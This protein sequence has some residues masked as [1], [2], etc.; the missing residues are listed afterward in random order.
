MNNEINK[1]EDV[2]FDDIQGRA[3]K[4]IH[5]FETHGEQAEELY[6]S[7]KGVFDLSV[8][9]AK[10]SITATGGLRDLAESAKSL[11]GIRGDA[12]A[13][14]NNAFS[15]LM[16]V[17]DF[18]LKKEKIGNEGD[19]LQSNALLMRQLAES[20]QKQNSVDKKPKNLTSNPSTNV[21]EDSML[22][23]RFS[24]IRNGSIK[25]NVNELSMKHDFNGVSYR[26]DIN[27]SEMVALDSS[28]K[29]I[30]NYPVERIPE[31]FNFKRFDGGIPMDGRGKEIKPYI[32]G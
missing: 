2:D 31:V 10:N 25:V 6:T 24:D 3:S 13:A 29:K 11:S 23:Q 22:Q 17:A 5:Q 8:I 26:Y 27:K 16:K 1:N 32:G 7:F 14:T 20:L 12:I 30:E 28:G 15:A 4:Y 21:E 9:K 19:E 18:N